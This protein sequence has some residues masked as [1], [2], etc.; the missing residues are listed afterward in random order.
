LN[1]IRHIVISHTGANPRVGLE[2]IAETHVRHGYP[3]IVYQF[4]VDGA[5][6]VYKVSNLEEVAQ[7]DQRWSEQGV[8][9]C[10]TGNFSVQAPPLAQLDATGR[11][12]AWLAQNLG[13]TADSIVGLGE[14]TKTDGPGETFY[15]GPAWKQI[16]S[17]Q[18]RL[19]LAAFSG[20]E[21]T[22]RLKELH[23]AL[24]EARAKNRELA[25][26][27]KVAEDER[28]R[29]D[30]AYLRLQAEMA[31]IAQQLDTQQTAEHAGGIR[32][33]RWIDRLPRDPERYRT[34]RAEDARYVVIHHTGADPSV[35]L[36][37]LA[38][39]HRT[40]WPGLLFDFVVDAQGDVYQT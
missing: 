35:P 37:E 5:G 18:V 31:E 22:N 12:C 27:L 29:L 33:Y 10:L 11:L 24:E 40:Q 26:R 14:L 4:V 32:I 34:R 19:H 23:A 8:N 6:Q 36:S 38:A 28:V 9:I 2:R 3:G 21:D 13:L 20:V 7:P 15:K 17:R 30:A 39:M 1:Q 25:N 16:L